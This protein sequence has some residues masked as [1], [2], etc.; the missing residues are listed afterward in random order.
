VSA[1]ATG[2][3]WRNSRWKRQHGK[4]LV[5][6][7]VADVVN[8]VHDN[9]FWMSQAGLAAKAGVSRQT[10]SD[11]LSEAVGCGALLLLED[12][13][14]AGKPNRYRFVAEGGVGSWDRGV[15]AQ[16]TPGV[17]SL[18]T[19]GVK[20]LDTNTKSNNP[21]ETQDSLGDCVRRIFDA[22]LSATERDATRVVLNRVRREKIVARLNEGYSEDDLIAAV[23]GVTL[24]SWHM[25][26]NPGRKRYDD[27]TVVFRD[28][29]QVEKFRDLWVGG[30]EEKPKSA[31]ER[32][33]E[34][35][36]DA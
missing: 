24:S 13:Q 16:L 30:G 14:R 23:H 3:V 1:E 8:D 2:W 5:H 26:D 21:R 36:R 31:T 18:D 28:G 22:W 11:W 17:G 10:V 32:A 15:S 27:L 33:A 19:G 34:R 12:N 29:S 35:R 6:L 4:F 25:G 7:A 20:P 9:E